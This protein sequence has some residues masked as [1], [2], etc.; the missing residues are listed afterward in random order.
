MTNVEPR[1]FLGGSISWSP[2]NNKATEPLVDVDVTMR[3]F[4]AYNDSV[5]ATCQNDTD[6]ING[7]LMGASESLISIQNGPSWWLDTQCFCSGYSANDGWSSGLRVQTVSVINWQ[8]VSAVYASGDWTSEAL[9]ASGNITWDF[10]M[11]MDLRMRSD[12]GQINSSPYISSTSMTSY[13]LQMNMGCPETSTLSFHVPVQDADGD[14]VRC[15][16]Q[17]DTCLSIVSMDSNNCFVSVAP[18]YP[19]YLVL[20]LVLEDFAASDDTIRLSSVPA[21]FLILVTNNTDVCG[22]FKAKLLVSKFVNQ[23]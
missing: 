15:R 23:K 7:N 6:I 1:H 4:W 17:N 14:T 21:K 19:G 11:S 20:D 9:I 12:I 3:F 5:S 13:F 16:C 10:E 8:T 18:M 22:L 2:T